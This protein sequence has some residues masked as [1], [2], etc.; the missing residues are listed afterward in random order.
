[1]RKGLVTFFSWFREL[2]H[3]F[4]TWPGSGELDDNDNCTTIAF[5]GEKSPKKS[6]FGHCSPSSLR[7]LST[8][9][10]LVPGFSLFLHCVC[11]SF[12][13]MVSVCVFVFCCLCVCV[14]LCESNGKME[15]CPYGVRW[16]CVYFSFSFNSPLPLLCGIIQCIVSVM[17]IIFWMCTSVWVCV[18]SEYP[19]IVWVSRECSPFCEYQSYSV[20]CL[21]CYELCSCV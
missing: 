15:A 8:S 3:C 19:C 10:F 20:R 21:L 6:F 14:Y 5:F 12:T 2:G 4:F 18:S 16:V 9:L 7:F 13:V 11:S 17:C 1:M